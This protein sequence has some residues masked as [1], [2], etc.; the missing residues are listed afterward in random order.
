MAGLLLMAAACGFRPSAPESRA[1]YV[2]EKLIE[3]S[4]ATDD[5]RAVAVVPEGQDP[6]VLIGDVAT[7]TALVY[8]RGRVRFG[9]SLRTRAAGYSAKGDGLQVSVTVSEGLIM[10]GAEAARFRVELVRRD[11]EWVVARVSVD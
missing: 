3:Q 8:L 5:L 9:A 1:A 4:Q 11:S 2:I 6:D 7:R 10:T